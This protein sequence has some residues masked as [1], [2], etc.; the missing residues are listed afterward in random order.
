VR[1]FRC[2]VVVVA[3]VVVIAGERRDEGRQRDDELCQRGETAAERGQRYG[4]SSAGLLQRGLGTHTL[5]FLEA[6]VWS[7]CCT[8]FNLNQLF[9]PLCEIS[10]SLV[11]VLG[12]PTRAHTASHASA[13]QMWRWVRAP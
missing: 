1:L 2:D 7:L 13:R 10:M 12:V 5:L 8:L 9:Q 4:R 3:V 6:D 11:C